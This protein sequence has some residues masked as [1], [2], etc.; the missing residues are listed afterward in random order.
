MIFCISFATKFKMFSLKYCECYFKRYM[1]ATVK[2]TKYG[3]STNKNKLN[4]S[5]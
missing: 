3:I 1:E 5:I 4:K 2:S